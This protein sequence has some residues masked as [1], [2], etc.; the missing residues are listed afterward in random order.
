MQIVNRSVWCSALIVAGLIS[1]AAARADDSLSDSGGYVVT[2]L[3]SDLPGA[4]VTDSNLKNAWGVAFSPAAS[5][6]WIADNGTGLSS[7][8]DGDGTI[9][10]GSAFPVIIPCPP[11][12][13]QGSSCPTNS[14]PTGMVWNPSSKFLVPGTTAQA[15]FIFAS[16]DRLGRA[17]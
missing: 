1:A 16:E 14:S 17:G 13:G 6:F 3:V 7:L 15:A 10:S 11:K 9:V 8:Y 5:P 12:P 4:G 2:P